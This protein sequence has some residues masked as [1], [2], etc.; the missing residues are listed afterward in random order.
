MIK[1]SLAFLA[2]NVLLQQFSQ[3]NSPLFIQVL[4][5]VI[6]LVICLF[7][8]GYFVKSYHYKKTLYN[9]SLIISFFFCSFFISYFYATQSLESHF[10][11][12][13]ENNEIIVQGFIDSIPSETDVS[14]KFNF[15]IAHIIKPESDYNKQRIRLSWYKNYN[16]SSLIGLNVGDYW[17]FKVKLKRPSGLLNPGGRD[18][19][20]WLFSHQIRAVGYIREGAENKRINKMEINQALPVLQ[21]LNYGIDKI[22]QNLASKLDVILA[23]NEFKGIYL[24]LILG[25]KDQ[26]TQQQWKVF[27]DSGTNHLIAISGLHIGLFAAIGFFIGRYLWSLS[28]FLLR[29]YPA[30]LAGAFF[31]LFFAFIYAALAGFSIPTQRALIMISLVLSSLFF[32]VYLPP[33]LILS[34]ALILVLLIDPMASLSIGFW[35]SFAAV[36]IILYA[37]SK[38]L[39]KEGGIDEKAEDDFCLA[40]NGWKN[41]LKNRLLV[42]IKSSAQLSYLQLVLFIGLLPFGLLFFSRILLLS[43]LANFIAVP[44]MSLLIVPLVLL[45]AF[46]SLFYQPLASFL[47]TGISYLM[48]FLWWFLTKLVA[49]DMN[50]IYPNQDNII[51]IIITLIMLFLFFVLKISKK[52]KLVL[53]LSVLFLSLFFTQI[54]PKSSTQSITARW[55]NPFSNDTNSGE[56]SVSILD[57]GQGLSVV[58]KTQSHVLVYDTGNAISQNYNMAK[59]VLI[60]FLQ[61]QSITQINKLVLSHADHDHVGSAPSLLERYP[62]TSILTG[63]PKRLAKKLSIDA[64]QCESRQQWAWDGVQFEFVFPL[65]SFE[66][67]YKKSNNRS[68]VLLITSQSG[69]KILLTGDIE[70]KVESS[71]LGLDKIKNI[72]ILIAPHHGSKSSSSPDFIAWLKPKVV[73]FTNGYLNRY[74]FPAKQVVR[75]YKQQGSR[76]F[77]TQNGMIKI[78]SGQLNTQG[79]LAILEYRKTRRSYWNR[80][81][82]AVQ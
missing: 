55:L 68:C 1:Y 63:E 67:H 23:D 76:L 39:K 72:D 8:L 79:R 28:Q 66:T 21:K 43:P 75:H 53:V 20:K 32:R 50:I 40:S 60:P 5:A 10:P 81:Y 6:C 56:F 24:A 48:Q 18:Y 59:L 11:K 9:L 31:A 33:L 17:Q 27:L 46:I 65:H 73:V 15:R 44:L 45:A 78:N 25:I 4:Y 38:K 37:L 62:V 70:K 54:L 12:P 2:G 74:H 41:N 52:Y 29:H 71:L 35:L 57:V 47:F 34:Y 36:V 61:Y 49:F 82:K 7:I 80:D 14:I 77:S 51:L 30:Q 19:E 58:I 22:R 16:K 13:L 64:E 3:L 69:K 26:I 42:M